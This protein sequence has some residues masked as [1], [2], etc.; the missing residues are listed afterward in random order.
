MNWHAVEALWFLGSAVGLICLIAIEV[1]TGA[2][3]IHRWDDV[4]V[5]L[6]LCSAA[7]ADGGI[8]CHA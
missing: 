5:E 1:T 7:M 6:D 8:E 2:Q 3:T 4:C